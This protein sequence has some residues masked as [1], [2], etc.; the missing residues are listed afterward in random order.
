MKP[1][2]SASSSQLL[3]PTDRH[4]CRRRRID[5]DAGGVGRGAERRETPSRSGGEAAVG[6]R[7]VAERRVVQSFGGGEEQ[8]RETS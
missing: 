2:R 4:A 5:T 1:S 3:Y 6:R 8:G 7:T